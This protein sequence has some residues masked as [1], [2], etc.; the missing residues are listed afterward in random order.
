[1]GVLGEV[2]RMTTQP[3]TPPVGRVSLTVPASLEPAYSN[4][5]LITHSPSEFVLDFAQ[6]MPQVPHAR[7]VARVVTT[8]VHAKLILRALSENVARYEAQ[9][10]AITPPESSTLADQLFRPPTDGGP[11]PAGPEGG[12]PGAGS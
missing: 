7:V 9:F 4:F 12:A 2:T 8:P 11:S 1:L 3:G 5:A 10:G 6:V